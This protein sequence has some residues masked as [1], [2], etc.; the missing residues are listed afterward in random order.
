MSAAC[1]KKAPEKVIHRQILQQKQSG[2]I[3]ML[4][5]I[6]LIL[7]AQSLEALD[8]QN[9][10]PEAGQRYNFLSSLAL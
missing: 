2:P 9:L 8:L 6:R 7:T 3:V 10:G 5:Y 1:M 4:S